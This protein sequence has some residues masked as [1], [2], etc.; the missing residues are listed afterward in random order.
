MHNML[1]VADWWVQL[2]AAAAE[3]C[4]EQKPPASIFVHI[5]QISGDERHVPKS[6]ETAVCACVCVCVCVWL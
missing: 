1:L 5:V 4:V 6:S 2:L 3:L